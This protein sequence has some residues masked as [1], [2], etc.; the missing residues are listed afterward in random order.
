MSGSVRIGL[1]AASRIAEAAV[2]EPARAVEGIE[3]TAVAARDATRARQAAERW[4]IPHA[5][6]SYVEMLLSG[7]IDAT[8]VA[9]PASLHRQWVLASL[10]AGLHVLCEKPFA[11]NAEDAAA[12]AAANTDRVVME[13]FHWRYHPLV[14]LMRTVLDRLGPIERVD[15]W[16][17]VEEG[18]ISRTDIRWDLALG[19][20]ATM[21]LG[22]YPLSWMRWAV[23]AEPTVT[24]ARAEAT[25]DGVDAWLA[26]DLTWASGATGS[27]RSSMVAAAGGSGLVVRAEG[28]TM[29]VE[30][31]LAPQR[32]SSIMVQTPDG[33]ETI[34]VDRSSTYAHQMAAFRDAVLTGSAY[35]TNPM[36]A[37]AN[38]KAVDA[39]Y[40][41]A[42]LPVRPSHP[43]VEA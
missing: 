34:E 21:D 8:Y 22:C 42:G 5:F 2:I 32:G 6:G 18:R 26:A 12:I 1:V 23:G 30:N 15:A 31:P 40:L 24:S 38:M 27:F 14:D 25:D 43:D 35:P 17:E 3:V 19:G 11:A 41:A 28:G 33:S 20:G 13:G 9:T 36:D 7:E 4:D 16:F 39:C 10:D 29:R 37:V